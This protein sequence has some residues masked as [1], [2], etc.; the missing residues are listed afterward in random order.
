MQKYTYISESR[1]PVGVKRST[2]APVP[3]AAGAG[4][5]AEKKVPA[6]KK[7]TTPTSSADKPKWLQKKF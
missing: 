7:P 6:W 3:G 2:T 4:A 5:A 1:K